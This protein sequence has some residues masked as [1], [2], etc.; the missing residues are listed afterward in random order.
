MGQDKTEQERL[1]ND[2]WYKMEKNFGHSEYSE[3]FDRF[4][5]DYLTIK[6]G[7]IPK[8]KEVYLSFKK[9]S[10]QF[11]DIEN[12]VSD[13]Y[14]YS[15]YFVN[16]ALEKEQ[17]PELKTIFSDI[18]TLK[19]DVSY[20]LILNLYDDFKSNILTKNDFIEILKCIESYVF[21]RA[22]CG[23][24]TNS[25]NKTFATFYKDIDQ[26]R[27]LESFKA[28]MIL[29]DSYRRFPKNEEFKEEL[30]I[31][32]VYN[33]RNRNYLLRKFEN[34]DRKEI[35]N[36]ESYTI[37]HILPQNKNLS[38]QWK[39]ELGDNWK[40]VQEKY[41]HTIGNLTLTGYNPEL[42]DRPFK[43]KRDMKGGFRDSPIRLNRSLADLEIWD[44]N[45]IIKRAEILGDQAVNIWRYPI[46]DPEIVSN[47]ESQ[48][49]PASKKQYTI[50]D[51]E[52]LSV[53]S[54]MRPIFDELRKRILNLD[55]SIREEFLKLYV[56]YKTTTNFVDIVP[57]KSKLRISLNMEF[58]EIN[59]PRGICVDVSEKGRWG[60]GDVEIGLSTIEEI[61]YIMF[62]I[63]QAYE[64]RSE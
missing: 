27:Y 54:Q 32:D 25:L 56:A 60:N 1:Y 2:Y 22:I 59:D 57:L 43:E 35:V 52:H 49:K 7:N 64:L 26:E 30:T 11:Q 62:L 15:K 37:E 36:V 41:L 55:S 18:N 63:R 8:I 58:Q 39:Q 40:N 19:V 9:Y 38:N 3:L 53:D 5:R 28:I 16:I 21:R 20:P 4:M 23:I 51:H 50:E 61:D 33:F 13:V 42:S 10:K 24:P 12:L 14:K 31:K 6:T 47:Y 34:F 46:L 45:E 44:E 48:E 17:D 29:K